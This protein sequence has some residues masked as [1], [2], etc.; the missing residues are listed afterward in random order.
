M[1]LFSNLEL[2]FA[3]PYKISDDVTISYSQVNEH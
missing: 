3:Q 2:Q 1:K